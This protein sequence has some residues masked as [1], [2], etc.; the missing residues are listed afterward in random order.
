M[1]GAIVSLRVGS[2]ETHISL[3]L[4][5]R[6][7]LLPSRLL[8]HLIETDRLRNSSVIS[9]GYFL[10]DWVSEYHISVKFQTLVDNLFNNLVEWS[11]S[12]QFGPSWSRDR[13]IWLLLFL[14]DRGTLRWSNCCFLALGLF[15]L[16]PVAGVTS[17]SLSWLLG[18]LWQECVVLLKVI[19]ASKTDNI[20][21]L[22]WKIKQRALVI[23]LNSLIVQVCVVHLKAL[24]R[25]LGSTIPLILALH[26]LFLD[27]IIKIN[28]KIDLHIVVALFFNL[29]VLLLIL[30]FIGLWNLILVLQVEIWKLHCVLIDL[31]LALSNVLLGVVIRLGLILRLHLLLRCYAEVDDVV[32]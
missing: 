20:A 2:Q 18:R 15:L 11:C 14:L 24:I 22:I 12:G 13:L 19:V 27:D 3:V 10:V 32:I 5:D 6:L 1:L 4:V 21:I 16:L 8:K 28:T 7:I 17:F 30:I 25:N 26:I 9:R 23:V 31:V 29:G